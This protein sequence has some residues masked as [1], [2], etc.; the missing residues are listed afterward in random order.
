MSDEKQMDSEEYHISLRYVMEYRLQC[1]CMVYVLLDLKLI[2]VL[3]VMKRVLEIEICF[4][5]TAKTNCQVQL[6]V[7]RGI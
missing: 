5:P 4:L 7:Q 6:V 3:I 2:L 1:V